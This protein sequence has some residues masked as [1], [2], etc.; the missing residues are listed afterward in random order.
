MLAA[1]TLEPQSFAARALDFATLP[2]APGLA[3]DLARAFWCDRPRGLTPVS[4]GTVRWRCGSCLAPR[5]IVAKLDKPGRCSWKVER[6]TGAEAARL[7]AIGLVARQG[8]PSA[9][10]VALFRCAREL[11]EHGSGIGDALDA[12]VHVVHL[13]EPQRPGYDASH[14]NPE[15]PC[16]VFVSAPLGERYAAIRLAESLVHEAMH[17]QLT[18]LERH[19]RLVRDA[20]AKA[21]SPWQQTK[22]PALGLLHGLFVFRTIDVWLDQVQYSARE[23]EARRYAEQRRNEIAREIGAVTNLPASASLTRFGVLLARRLIE[24]R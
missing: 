14:S 6:L 13:L 3:S 15:L 1:R 10:E 2:W 20:G 9:S 5:E 19:E 24:L 7:E 8:P 23:G 11:A 4:Y 22:R 16:S 21:W 17:L 12:L 18:M